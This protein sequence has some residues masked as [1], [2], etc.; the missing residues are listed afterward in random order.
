MD[1]G[2]GAEIIGYGLIYS[3]IT[4]IVIAWF[5]E[6]AASR[7]RFEEAFNI[8]VRL[9]ME[10]LI[11]RG[12]AQVSATLLSEISVQQAV[13]QSALSEVNRHRIPWREKHKYYHEVLFQAQ[14]EGTNQYALYAYKNPVIPGVAILA[15]EMIFAKFGPQVVTDFA[16]AMIPRFIEATGQ[17]MAKAKMI[18]DAQR[19][20]EKPAPANVQEPQQ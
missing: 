5:L 18:N 17:A 4:G 15:A 9:F 14:V 10:M 12:D 6:R 11:H 7:R 20:V 8:L 19:Q 1:W 2:R 13:I 3:T 16:E